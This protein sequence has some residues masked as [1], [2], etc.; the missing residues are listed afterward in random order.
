MTTNITAFPVSAPAVVYLQD[1]TSQT[2]DPQETFSI[3]LIDGGFCTI[4][5]TTN[6]DTNDLPAFAEKMIEFWTEFWNA[7]K[8]QKPEVNPL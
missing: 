4:S 7:L 5:D 6:L 2:I 8:D 1:G 3:Q